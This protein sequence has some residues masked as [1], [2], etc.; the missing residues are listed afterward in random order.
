MLAYEAKITANLHSL[1]AVAG[2]KFHSEDNL[3]YRGETR[4]T[5]TLKVGQ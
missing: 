1:A 3:N 4:K 2:V 5:F